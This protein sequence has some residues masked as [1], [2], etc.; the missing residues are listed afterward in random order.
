MRSI[1]TLVAYTVCA[2]DVWHLQHAIDGMDAAGAIDHEDYKPMLH[3]EWSFRN[4]TAMDTALRTIRTAR[5]DDMKSAAAR[6]LLFELKES[7]K[8]TT[9]RTNLKII[10]LTG[11]AGAGKDTTAAMLSPWRFT[12][13][14]FADALRE[15][16]CNAFDVSN[17]FF[18]ERQLKESPSPI[19]AF[20]RSADRL[21]RDRVYHLGLDLN[22]PRSPRE[23]LQVWGTEY[24]RAADPQYWVGQAAHQVQSLFRRGRMR[25]VITDVRFPNEA[26]WVRSMGG[27]I[28]RVHR[29]VSLAAGAH[30]SDVAMTGQRIDREVH[31][32]GSLHELSNE[33]GRLLELAG[34]CEGFGRQ[35][36]AR[37]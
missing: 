28:W 6:R 24:R 37:S 9:M 5:T 16:V 15:E 34:L 19:F 25:V 13:I 22:Q 35:R 20:G 17:V 12:P 10:G 18:H 21:F 31:N 23:V 11:N 30:Q 2:F 3:G 32:D 26:Q 29:M 36:E 27:E 1:F 33:V 14:A 4:N 7:L 8:P